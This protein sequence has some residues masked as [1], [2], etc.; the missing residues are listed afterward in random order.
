MSKGPFLRK[1]N[2]ATTFNFDLFEIDGVDLR[3]DAVHASGDTVI[4]K[5]EAAEA[6]TANAFVDE[7]QT[8][9]ILLSATEMQAARIKVIIVD[10]TATKV[11]LDTSFTI[12]TYGH[13]SAAHAFDLDTA[14]VTLA[15]ATHTGAVIPTVTTLTNLPSIPANWLTAAGIASNAITAAKIAAAALNGKGDWNIGKTGYSLSQAFPSNFSNLSI[16]AGGLVDITQAAADKVWSTTTRTLTAISTAIA[17][18][19]WNVLESAVVTASTMGLK[20]KNNLNATVSSRQPSGA[21]DLNADQSGVTVGTVTTLTN[22]PSIPANWLTATGIASNAITAAKI[23]ASAL[24]GKGD[25]NIGKTGYSLTQPFP[26]NFADLSITFSTG[27]VNI[28]Q[29]AADKVWGTTV[30]TIT[31]FGATFALEVWHVLESAIVTA[32]TIGLKIKT[33]L[34]ATISSRQPSGSVNLNADQSG[35]TI[36]TVNTLATAA[37]NT[38]RDAILPTQNVAFS[39]IEFLFVAASDHVTPVT[40]ATGTGVTRSIDGGAFGAGTGTLAEVG[41]GIYQYDASAADMNG[42]IITFRFTATG[43]TPGAADDVFVTIVTGGGV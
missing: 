36:G 38:I 35:V 19:F 43:G 6:N 31:A 34:D 11:W 20:V 28:T 16:T 42:G 1:Y 26:T 40:V 17:L 30:R 12:E 22:L 27:L 8:Y 4:M 9:S 2:V 14:L 24:N 41:N 10:Q 5:D 15:A 39:N 3:I 37:I 7:G 29:A 18:S 25:W 23:A 21:V 13:A 32:S 33:N